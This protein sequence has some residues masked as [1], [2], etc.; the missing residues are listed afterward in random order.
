MLLYTERSFVIHNQVFP[1]SSVF[2]AS[3][4][5][6]PPSRIMGFCRIIYFGLVFYCD[7]VSEVLARAVGIYIH[8]PLFFYLLCV[9]ILI[10][11]C[12]CC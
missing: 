5:V 2:L 8:D 3:R 10:L 6:E 4:F 7:W 11:F 1:Q 9:C 12:I